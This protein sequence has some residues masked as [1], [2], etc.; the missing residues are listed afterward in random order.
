MLLVTKGRHA[1]HAWAQGV[2][3]FWLAFL[4]VVCILLIASFGYAAVLVALRPPH[5]RIRRW[6]TERSVKKA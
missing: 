4:M 2:E 5:P 6:P 3:W 1:V